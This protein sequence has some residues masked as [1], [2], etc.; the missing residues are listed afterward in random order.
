ML[1]FVFL[2]VLV[3]MALAAGATA[4]EAPDPQ[5]LIEAA[6]KVRNPDQPFR[7]SSRITEYV[8][9]QA[10]DSMDLV[11]F[12][13]EDSQTRQYGNLVRYVAP[14]R[15]LG[16]LVL[17]DGSRMWFYDPAS[18]ASV[19]ISAQQRLIGQASNGDVMTVNLGRDYQAKLVGP[20]M[21]QDADRVDRACWHL[22]LAASTPEAM[23]GR[24]EYWTEKDTAHPV[25]GKFYSD[26]G[27][28]L[29]I[30][31]Y[32]KYEDRLGQSRPMETIIINAVDASQVTIM[33]TSDLRVEDIPE[34]WFQRDFLPRMKV[35]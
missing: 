13:R 35:D 3:A 6:D 34:T 24:I 30:A 20:E 5:S 33:T 28:L 12:A 16:K 4:A 14:A 17:L 7:L 18:K 2:P 29:K 31:Y 9:G 21:L 8:G 1:K 27:R 11:I 25:K 23:Y 15:D 26:S 22:D 10:R 32:H 19:R